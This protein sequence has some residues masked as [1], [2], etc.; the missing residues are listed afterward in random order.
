VSLAGRLDDQDLATLLQSLATNGSTG[1]LALTRRDGHAILAFRVG[2]IIY[3]A[4][5]GMR[6][7][8]GNILVLRGLVSESDLLVALERQHAATLPTRLGSVLVQMGK[9]DE[10]ALREVMKQQTEDV[11]AELVR[12]KTGFFKFE[13][14]VFAPGGEVEVDIKDFLVTEG[15][16]P[17]EMLDDARRSHY[18]P[19]PAALP[20]APPPLPPLPPQL[21]GQET[22]GPPAT[23]PLGA[24]VP[25]AASPAVTAEVTLRLMRYAAQILNR[26]VLFL[27]RPDEVRGMGQFGVQIPGRPAADQV[28]DTVIPLGEP[29]VFR[30]VVERRE[31][32]RGPLEDS[33][34]NRHLVYRLGGQQPGEI[35]A[36]PMI[37]GG[38]V[39]VILYGDTLPDVRPIGP[40]D[41]LEFMIVDAALA[42]ERALIETREKTLVE[43]RQ[44]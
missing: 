19:E 20:L 26:G 5:S 25:E 18:P 10:K 36:V 28:R 33:R 3:A 16:S 17:Q 30:D 35:V 11:I 31:T 34:W 43:K 15:F 8:F 21:P 13:P 32:Y 39:T 44:K 40:M 7:T 12:W 37:V 1:K 23:V 29:S 24:I 4:S 41:T 9:V 2:K 22:A 14:L 42:M 6:E 38:A 27:V